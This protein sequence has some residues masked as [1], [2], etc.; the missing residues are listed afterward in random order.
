MSSV[1]VPFLL[2]RSNVVRYDYMY[3]DAMGLYTTNFLTVIT[4][5]VP[6]YKLNF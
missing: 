3:N 1:D 5:N 4:A 6:V 2:L